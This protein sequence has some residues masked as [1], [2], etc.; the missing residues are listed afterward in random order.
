MFFGYYFEVIRHYDDVYSM[1]MVWCQRWMQ[2]TGEKSLPTTRK[3]R[4]IGTVPAGRKCLGSKPRAEGVK[5]PALALGDDVSRFS[6][7]LSLN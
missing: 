3:R 4:A 1:G 5:V 7:S 6:L 2:T